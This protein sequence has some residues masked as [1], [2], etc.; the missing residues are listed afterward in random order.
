[1]APEL[2]CRHLAEAGIHVRAEDGKLLVS[3][4]SLLTSDERQLLQYHKPALLDFLQD[5]TLDELFGA[6]DRVC[7]L[8]DDGKQAREDMRTD[9]LTTPPHLRAGLLAYF[10][11]LQELHSFPAGFH[12]GFHRNGGVQVE[13][14]S[15][16]TNPEST[17]NH[18]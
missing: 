7:D 9:V 6:A 3:P 13:T 11:A 8:Y 10:T 16:T 14:T 5:K 4:M 12:S 2:I 1:M 17:S 18:A 15:T